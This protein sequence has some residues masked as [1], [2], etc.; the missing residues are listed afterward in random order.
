M[1]NRRWMHTEVKGYNVKEA[2]VN[3]VKKHGL[4][5][6][7]SDMGDNWYHIAVYC[8]DEEAAILN[9]IIDAI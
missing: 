6:E 3:A 4:Y 8:N 5:C 9:D 2:I 7:P 1:N